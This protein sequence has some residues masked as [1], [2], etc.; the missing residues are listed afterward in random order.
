MLNIVLF[1]VSRHCVIV[2]LGLLASYFWNVHKILGVELPVQCVF[3]TQS[4]KSFRSILFEF[5]TVLLVVVKY[6]LLET[7]RVSADVA[8][9]T[10]PIV[11]GHDDC[12]LE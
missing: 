8:L 12:G 5:Q 3:E 1:P 11:A 2:L 4:T 6:A 10:L 7:H 9:P